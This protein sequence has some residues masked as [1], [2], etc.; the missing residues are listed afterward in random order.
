MDE[1]EDL[2]GEEG[3][4]TEL[5]TDAL[6]GG[7][8]P[9]AIG[10]ATGILDNYERDYQSAQA[11]SRGF[12]E[13]LRKSA[14]ERKRV[15]TEAR[16]KIL[17]QRYNPG[18]A[19][20]AVSQA[21]AQP[22]RSGTIAEAMGNVSGALRDPLARRREFDRNREA[23]ISELD[24][25]AAGLYDPVTTAELQLSELNRRLGTQMAGKALDVLRR[26]NGRQ[27]NKMMEIQSATLQLIEMGVEPREAFNRAT[28]I[29]YGREVLEMVPEL[30][31]AVIRDKLGR[32]VTEIP[33]GDPGTGPMAPRGT[34]QAA[35]QTQVGGP[36]TVT[37]PVVAQPGRDPSG[38]PS[39]DPRDAVMP[40]RMT[41]WQ[42][43]DAG[44][45]LWSGL[46]AGWNIAAG[47]VGLPISTETEQ[48]RQSIRNGV[49]SMLRALSVDPD[50]PAAREIDRI[51]D[52]INIL[53][54]VATNPPVFKERVRTIDTYMRD[55]YRRAIADANDA[56][57]GVDLRRQRETLAAEIR[58][59]LPAL[60]VPPQREGDEP[61]P[62]GIPPDIAALWQFMS[63][64]ARELAIQ[65]HDPASQEV[66]DAQ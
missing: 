57:L 61:V 7:P 62:P 45:G 56:A 11:A 51:R 31:L 1:E 13:Q 9:E 10:Q 58:N 35:T 12:I 46:T 36:Q 40:G 59:F 30:G 8:T 53:P 41:L 22:T 16:E 15:L 55:L 21:L 3:T 65:L 4:L 50:D 37:P 27:T 47:N 2:F 49:Q 39:S 38:A 44:T 48:A 5:L 17:R 33:I 19:L 66:P 29:A 23:A 28:N 26:G 18:E 20:L 6:G 24:L 42:A 64:R 14:D 60:G 63:P 52:E 34:P 43:A 25:Q 32:T 54:T